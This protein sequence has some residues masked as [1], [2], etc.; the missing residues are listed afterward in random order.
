MNVCPYFPLLRSTCACKKHELTAGLRGRLFKY[1]GFRVLASKTWCLSRV[2]IVAKTNPC[3]FQILFH[4]DPSICEPQ[5]LCARGPDPAGQRIQY[6]NSLTNVDAPQLSPSVAVQCIIGKDKV[7]QT[8]VE[9]EQ[10]WR[11]SSQH[12]D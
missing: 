9:G 6:G 2:K 1:P 4:Q 10:K 11:G 12:A 3:P 5:L 8:V 7:C